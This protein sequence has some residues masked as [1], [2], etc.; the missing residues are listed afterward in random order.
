MQLLPFKLDE[1]QD[2]V[3]CV[4]RKR[5]CHSYLKLKNLKTSGLLVYFIQCK[6]GF[7]L[8]SPCCGS[9]SAAISYGLWSKGGWEVR[10]ADP[11][12][13]GSAKPPPSTDT[14]D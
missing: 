5:I 13:W 14:E 3:A 4:I 7:R 2:F 9:D 11:E 12:Y 10:G 8:P 6:I 1:R